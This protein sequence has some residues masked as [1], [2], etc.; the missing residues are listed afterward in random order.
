[1]EGALVSVEGSEQ[2]P[3]HLDHQRL[4][5]TV[6]S[7]AQSNVAGSSSMYQSTPTSS[8]PPAFRSVVKASKS[9]STSVKIIKAT[10]ETTTS[11]KVHFNQE[12]QVHFDVTE[13]TA[14]VD[15]LLKEV[16]QVWGEGYVLVTINDLR[17]EDSEGTRG[18]YPIDVLV[19]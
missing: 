3:V 10:M 15:H 17:L 4:S 2:V 12:A 13:S 18:E 1:M 7:S 9:P 8:L 16:Q 19:S 6:S 14:N 11:G 5:G